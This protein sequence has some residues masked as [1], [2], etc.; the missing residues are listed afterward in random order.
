MYPTIE[1][2]LQSS[3]DNCLNFAAL[4]AAGAH[5]I[6]LPEKDT[7]DI[8]MRDFGTVF[9]FASKYGRKSVKFRYA[10]LEFEVW[11]HDWDA[12]K[13]VD[14]KGKDFLPEVAIAVI[15]INDAIQNIQL[16]WIYFLQVQARLLTSQLGSTNRQQ[17]P[18][19]HASSS[20]SFTVVPERVSAK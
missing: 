18:Q 4:D 11:T 9:P 3:L 15:L 10:Y 17:I 14:I 8:W 19:I 7:L 20:I 2:A 16:E 12:I 13:F 1:N 6:G 5:Y